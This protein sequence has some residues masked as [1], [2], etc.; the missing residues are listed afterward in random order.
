MTLTRQTQAPDPI[1][2]VF[3]RTLKEVFWRSKKSV[4]CSVEQRNNAK[5]DFSNRERRTTGIFSFFL[6]FP[7]FVAFSDVIDF[8]FYG[9]F[10]TISS[11]SVP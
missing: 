6:F 2:K 10:G 9:T 7:F 4:K 8:D 11:L 3:H 5:K 1:P